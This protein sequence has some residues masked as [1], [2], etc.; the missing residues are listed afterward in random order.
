[1]RA[2]GP[3]SNDEMVLS[4]LRGEIDSA[5]WGPHYMAVLNQIRTDRLSLIDN[6]DLNDADAN[7]ARAMVLGP[8]RGY[9]RPDQR[10]RT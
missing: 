1:M 9:G 3:A 6:A 4:F 8:I 2:V 5:R 10:L 7:R